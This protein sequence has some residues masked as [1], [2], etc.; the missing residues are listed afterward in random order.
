MIYTQYNN[1]D[2][3]GGFNDLAVSTSADVLAITG[4]L[5]DAY[6]AIILDT[7]YL[8]FTTLS[9]A[10]FFTIKISRDAAGDELLAPAFTTGV[11]GVPALSTGETTATD[12]TVI[13]KLCSSIPKMPTALTSLYITIESDG[14]ATLTEAYLSAQA[15]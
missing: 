13:V 9:S 7:L 1:Q 3:T 15:I 10:T 11:N 2:G 5:P 4:K 12:G 6:A 14:T 8:Y